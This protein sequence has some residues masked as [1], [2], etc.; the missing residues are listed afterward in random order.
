MPRTVLFATYVV[1]PAGVALLRVVAHARGRCLIFTGV[2][3]LV[4]LVIATDIG[5]YFTGRAFG[6]PKIA[7]RISP[8][9]TWSGLVGGMLAAGLVALVPAYAFAHGMKLDLST[10]V[11]TFLLG[12]TAAVVAQV[13]DFFESWMKRRAGVKDSSGLIPGHGGLL[14]RIDG[15]LAVLCATAIVFLAPHAM[16]ML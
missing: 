3:Y 4:A 2:G 10:L 1:W 8:S 16:A 7:R 14:D 5:A 12:M 15:L 13:G 6:G 11:A 9:K